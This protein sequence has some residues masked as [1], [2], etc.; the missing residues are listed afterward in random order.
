VVPRLIVSISIK[1]RMVLA[2]FV[3]AVQA[4]ERRLLFQ[5]ETMIK[6]N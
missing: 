5:L 3:L 1:E 2:L 4:T 6:L